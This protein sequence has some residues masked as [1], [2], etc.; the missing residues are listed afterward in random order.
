[1]ITLDES[2]YIGKGWHKRTYLHPQDPHKCIKIVYRLP[3]DDVTREL[4]YRELLEKR[5]QHPPMLTN[6]YGTVETNQ[7]LGY[8]YEFVRDYDGKPS[9]S[10]RHIL[11]KANTSPSQENIALKDRVMVKFKQ[12]LF[13]NP[14][15]ITDI[16]PEN[17][18]VQW[19]GPDSFQ[20]R[21]IDNIGA[22]SKYPIG[23]Y[24]PALLVKKLKKKWQYLED[25]QHTFFPKSTHT[26]IS[27]ISTT[28]FS[29]K[30][31]FGGNT[32]LLIV[33]H[34]DDEINT[35]GA[36]IYGAAQE[37]MQVICAFVTNGDWEFDGR[38]RLQEAITMSGEMG[39][40]D[41][42]IVFLGFPDGGPQ[43]QASVYM[44]RKDLIISSGRKETYGLPTHPDFSTQ[45]FGKPTAY[46]YD[47]LCQNLGELILHYQP[48]AIIA[49]DYDL[50]TDHRMTSIMVEETI[51][52]MIQEKRLARLPRVFKNF[53]YGTGYETVEDFYKDNLL[54]T[55]MNPQVLSNPSYTTTN[56]SL[57]WKDRLR[58]PVPDDC[59]CLDL[60]ENPL[61]KAMYSHIS[62]EGYKR[63]SRLINGDAV[64]WERRTD[65]LALQASVSTSSGN[66]H[67][68]NDFIL[69]STQDI[70]TDDVKPADYLWSPDQSDENKQITLSWDSPQSI[71]ELTLYGNIDRDNRVIKI[72]ISDDI[73]HTENYNL[74]Q[75][76]PSGHTIPWPHK[77]STSKLSIKIIEWTGPQ[78]GFSE[79]EIFTKRN[80]YPYLQITMNDHFAYQWLHFPFTTYPHV[81]VYCQGLDTNT[82]QWFVNNKPIAY[83]DINQFLKRGPKEITIRCQTPDASTWSEI[84]FTKVSI[85]GKIRKI[86]Q[87]ARN[88]LRYQRSRYKS[89]KQ[90]KELEKQYLHKY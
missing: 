81:D 43:A 28:S 2:L 46:T 36:T 22:H 10:V 61:Y 55:V 41:A 64:L 29:Y 42:N 50:H 65:N 89:K 90:A 4:R 12:D 79:I 62:Q 85:L 54:S 78:A 20:I 14:I 13:Q 68:I 3:M 23:L 11:E 39:L 5:N 15:L 80:L 82:L 35:A 32:L 40:N 37:G 1:M 71:D 67:R 49:T 72:L 24:V 21:C 34:E 69:L 52:R 58:L 66:A 17:F 53:A 38:V 74:P 8:I 25:N 31:F 6:Y 18:M 87:H 27:P 51:G 60:L 75:W 33:P 59:R 19:T 83:K 88:F 63:A 48:D 47:G 44:N 57:A 7:G 86:S 84:T 26:N 76:Y 9:V 30:D 16:D 56:P 73:G 77:E 70:R 45:V